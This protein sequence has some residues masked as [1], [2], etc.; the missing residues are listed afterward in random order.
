MP[1]KDAKRAFTRET[2]EINRR[3]QAEG[4]GTDA[5]S[6]LAAILAEHEAEC[7]ALAAAQLS[8]PAEARREG[9]AE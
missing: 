2:D 5:A 1:D 4:P 8:A 9:A 3:S 6:D 7:A